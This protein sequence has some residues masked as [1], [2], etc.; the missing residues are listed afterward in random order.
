VITQ[1]TTDA[2][3]GLNVGSI[4]KGDWIN[5]NVNVA[6]A[7]TYTVGF[8]IATAAAGAGFQLKTSSGTVLATVTLPNT[9]N[10]QAWQTVNATVTLPAG[11]QTLQLTST[12]TVN[13]NFNWMQFSALQTAAA[14][15]GTIEAESYNAMSGILT[16]A[17]TDAGGGLNVGSIDKGDWM[18]Y[19][20][21]VVASGNY[22][23]SF[24]I[25]TAAAGASFQLRTSSGAVLATLS[26]PNT[27]NYQVWQTVNA[28]VSLP[29]G[30][31]TLQLYSTSTVNWNINRIQFS[32]LIAADI[33]GKIEAENYNS[34]AGI[35]A[36]T[37]TDA[38][39][40]LNAGSIDKGDWMNYYVNV[41]A[42]GTYTVSF[43]IATV[44]AGAGFQLKTSS[45]TVLA[46]VTLPNTGNYQVWQ[47]VNA[48]VTL[49]AGVQTLQLYSTS[50]ANWNINW[51]QFSSGSSATSA[52][53][54][55]QVRVQ[56]AT[57][58]IHSDSLDIPSS[59]DLYPNPA[60]DHITL[61]I[62][63]GYTGPMS[64]QVV[65]L[66]GAVL[67]VYTSQ[68]DGTSVR[69]DLPCD[70]FPAGMYFVRV[71]IG[72]HWTIVKKWMKL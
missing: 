19:N 57:V 5:Y 44:A 11:A 64:V 24:R 23:V 70:N 35:S 68:K 3:G 2:G 10:Y 29:A 27:K 38:G 26:L 58:E 55:T 45:G 50:T 18:N 56:E 33:P 63:N 72:S 46:T 67:K 61:N 42:A 49:P 25:A 4:D 48:T 17:T 12:S 1:A 16:Q 39:G 53:E 62:N 20:V 51:M 32:Y 54:G 43:R 36:E 60:R 40:G 66:S 52:L 30:N 13:W 41:A 22:A 34:M 14:I 21:N 65:N 31:Q 28:I 37:T 9:G 8:R 7:G 59:F 15:P 69:M 47:T 6:T 71:Q